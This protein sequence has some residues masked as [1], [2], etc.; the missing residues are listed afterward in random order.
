M[1]DS[2]MLRDTQP[3]PA[4]AGRPNL[5][6]VVA[7]YVRDE[8]LSGRL[9][10]GQRIDQDLVAEVTGVSRL[11]VREALIT[12][13]AEGL[14][15]NVARRG[16]YVAEL[17]PEDILDHYEMF[18]LVSGLAA[19]RAA[20]TID[21]ASLKRLHDLNEQMTASSDPA[22]HDRFNYQFHQLINRNA[23][24]GR[25]LAVLR[26]LSNSMP[27]HFYEHDVASSRKDTSVVEHRDIIDALTKR[28]GDR[29]AQAMAEHFRSTGEQAVAMLRSVGF[30]AGSER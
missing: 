6:Q 28:D 3:R 12:L 27:T 23:S 14:V 24:S 17:R 2:L 9:R 16:S 15:S 18:G 10:S 4:G 21:E 19:R 8:I 29:A 25:L 5:K 11:P 22:D 20:T 1:A 30:W 7:Q 13:E 26:T